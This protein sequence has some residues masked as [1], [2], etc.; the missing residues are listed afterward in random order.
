NG[1]L[2]TKT[3]GAQSTSYTYDVLGNLTHV[4]LPEGAVI[5]YVADAL[6]RRVAKK[7]GGVLVKGFL[8]RDQLRITAELDGSG[9]V[10]ATF[11][12]GSKMN[13]PD[14][15]LKGGNTYRI[16]T[17]HL[18]SPRVVVDTATGTVSQRVEYDEW[19]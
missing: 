3:S 19:G 17:D 15:M 7:V 9:N 14:Y 18:G 1:E 4:E 5:D 12:Y 10:V 13:V 11:L 8:Y 6:G 2:Q 16:F